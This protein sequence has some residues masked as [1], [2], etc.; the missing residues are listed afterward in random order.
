[1]KTE[2]IVKRLEALLADIKGHQP[3]EGG[4]IQPQFKGKEEPPAGWK[5]A[6]VTYWVVEE[7]QNDRGAYTQGRVGLSWIEADGERQSCFL[8]TFDRALIL[9]IDPLQKGSKVEYRAF[10]DKSGKEKLADLV[11][12]GAPGR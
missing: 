3:V 5:R 2:D 11:V 1:M 12:T 7:K 10:R 9:K 4:D 6:L 8:S